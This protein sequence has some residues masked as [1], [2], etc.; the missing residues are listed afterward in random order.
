MKATI[1]TSSKSQATDYYRTI[2]PFSR[3]ALQKKFELII[4]QQEKAAWHDIYNTDI[5]IIQRPNS[6]ASL[7]IMAD[8]KR[9]G[10]AVI[11]DFDD[12]L[13]NVPEDNPASAY[14]SNPQ[15]QK[16][17]QDTFIFADVIIVSTQK[18]YDLYKPLSHDKPMF[19][20]PN[21]WSPSDLPM[22]K[23]EEQHN[24]PRFV[25]RG[26]STHFADLHTIKEQLNKAMELDTEFTFFGMPKF[27]MYDFS[28]KANF[29]EWNSMFIYFTF[30]QRIQGDYGYYPL[31]RNEFNE[32]KSNIFAIECLA[33]GMPVLADIYFKEFNIPGVWCY[34]TPHQFFDLVLAIIAGNINK[35]SLVKDGRKYLNEVLHI[36]LLNRKR[37]EILK[38]L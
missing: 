28:K 27:M 37:W 33:N 9:M 24:P 4:C 20:I 21:G 10:K 31:V 8:A 3:L 25:W 12:H 6:T 18:L 29:V 26:G 5:V 32:S 22:T 38:G 1:F 13:L 7:G 11:I 23:V 36:D 30:M 17:I 15:V 35:I 14:F 19:V 16:Q 34:D 2:G